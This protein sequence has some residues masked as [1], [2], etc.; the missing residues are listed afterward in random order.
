MINPAVAESKWWEW[1]LDGLLLRQKCLSLCGEKRS[2][3]ASSS[4]IV[5]NAQVR[6]TTWHVILHAPS[7]RC[8]MSFYSYS[9]NANQCA[10]NA[11]WMWCR[12]DAHCQSSSVN[13]PLE[14]YYKLYQFSFQNPNHYSANKRNKYSRASSLSMRLIVQVVV[15]PIELVSKWVW[16]IRSLMGCPLMY[17]NCDPLFWLMLC[18]SQWATH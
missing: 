3:I 8:C 11:H 7:I 18:S 14:T 2:T 1:L 4:T 16:A 10:F 17:M 13:R 9:L 5:G 15:S 6:G 12:S